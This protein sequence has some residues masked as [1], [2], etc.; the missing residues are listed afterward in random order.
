MQLLPN[1]QQILQHPVRNQITVLNTTITH[2]EN[3]ENI[4]H[5][6]EKLLWERI[7]K[8]LNRR[9]KRTLYST[10]CDH[11]KPAMRKI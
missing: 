1:K 2:I 3:V 8:Y 9:S 5:W 11:N 4:I 7:I 10:Y 6:N